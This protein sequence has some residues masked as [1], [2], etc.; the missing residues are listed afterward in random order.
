MNP[1]VGQVY[2]RR[3]NGTAEVVRVVALDDGWAEF[4]FLHGPARSM[5]AGTGRCKVKNFARSGWTLTDERDDY[6]HLDGA[7]RFST[8]VVLDTKGEPILRCSA[9]R[10]AFYL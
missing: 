6:A 7:T 1:G 9:K 4:R 10:A 3:R 2:A 5:R 8:Y